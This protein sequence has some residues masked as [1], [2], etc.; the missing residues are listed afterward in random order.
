MSAGPSATNAHCHPLKLLCGQLTYCR[1]DPV[2]NRTPG[3][4]AIWFVVHGGCTPGNVRVPVGPAPTKL[5]PPSPDW[6]TSTECWCPLTT[7][8]DAPMHTVQTLICPRP[9]CAAPEVNVNR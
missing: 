7:V 9:R 3:A 1:P 2:A 4:T 8:A 5:L 6:L